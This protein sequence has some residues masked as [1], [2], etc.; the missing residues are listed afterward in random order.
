MNGNRS[1]VIG[2]NLHDLLQSIEAVA[3]ESGRDPGSVR[4]VAVTKNFPAGDVEAAYF[5]GQHVFG[6]NRVQELAAKAAELAPRIDCQWHMIGTLQTNKVKYLTGLVSLIHSVDSVKLLEIIQGRAERMGL[7]QGV[8]LQV[9]VSGE[10]TKHGFEPSGLDALLEGREKFP[11]VRIQGLMTMAPYY[12]DPE[13]ARP[14]F[15][16]LRELRDRLAADHAMPELSELSM[17][18]TGDY[19]QA[20]AEGATLVRIG[21]AIFGQRKP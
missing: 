12:Q 19:R 5:H 18:M 20:I 17:G 9:N 11:H 6:E 10:D 2:R 13:L 1:E 16:R 4:L 21:S 8:L 7:A 14:V 15:A 3:R